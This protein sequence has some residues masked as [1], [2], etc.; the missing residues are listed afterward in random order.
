MG[1]SRF[2]RQAYEDEMFTTWKNLKVL[3][4][5]D[6]SLSKRAKSA[7]RK[8]ARLWTNFTCIN[9]TEIG[10]D[11]GDVEEDEEGEQFYFYEYG[12]GVGGYEGNYGE[13][14]DEDSD[15]EDEDVD[16]EYSS[17][18]VHGG[19]GCRSY[20]GK[21]RL[22]NWQQNITLGR[23]CETIGTAAHELAHALGFVH[24]QQRHDRDKYITVIFENIDVH[25]SQFET[26][27]DKNND[28]YG[29]PYDYG[30]VMH[31]GMTAGSANRTKP[32][33]VP[34]DGL[35]NQTL[36]SLLISFYDLLMMNKHYN[37]TGFCKK[38]DHDKCK[39]HGFAHPRNCS[40]CLCPSGYGGDF[41]DRRAPNGLHVEV[42]LTKLPANV[43]KEGCIYGGVEVKALADQGLTGYRFC[44][45]GDVNT[46]LISNTSTLPVLTYM[47]RRRND[48]AVELE[49]RIANENSE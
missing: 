23:K 11:D 3:Y 30:S 12:N 17:I 32:T 44:S 13:E 34:K 37:C 22:T 10:G 43:S 27:S 5:F 21:L 26:K 18:K 20:D 33:L 29:L 4:E 49:Y 25:R 28:N 1:G 42:R 36:G 48:T 41:C 6:E 40:Q 2:K 45:E 46:T 16:D 15:D 47:R 39:N 24:T 31:Y 35:Y 14:S 19:Y 7:F 8:A 9:I 38:E